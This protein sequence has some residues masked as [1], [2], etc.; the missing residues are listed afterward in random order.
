MIEEDDS[1]MGS[2][3]HKFNGDIINSKAIIDIEFGG[4]LSKDG[5]FP[6]PDMLQKIDFNGINDS[7]KKEGGG[8]I[9]FDPFLFPNPQEL[10]EPQWRSKNGDYMTDDNKSDDSSA[11]ASSAVHQR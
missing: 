1:I 11:R 5:S 9:N 10:K 2:I 3:S 4:K 7:L 6:I 8:N